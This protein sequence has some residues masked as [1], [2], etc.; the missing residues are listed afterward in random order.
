MID[1][2]IHQVVPP[3]LL[4]FLVRSVSVLKAL[5]CSSARAPQYVTAGLSIIELT[6]NRPTGTKRDSR[7]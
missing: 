5:I 3:F 1:K 4:P 7:F 2:T 6:E